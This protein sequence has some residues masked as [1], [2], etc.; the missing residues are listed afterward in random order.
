MIGGGAG[1]H[2]AQLG[3]ALKHRHGS[4][5]L[6]SHHS[7]NEHQAS[8]V[9]WIRPWL[10]ASWRSVSWSWKLAFGTWTIAFLVGKEFEVME[11]VD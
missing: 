8:G 4:V 9:V 10:K 3:I 5:F 11:Q 7:E 1:G 6:W 2:G